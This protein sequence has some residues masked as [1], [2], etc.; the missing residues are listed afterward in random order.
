MS[1][2]SH[3]VEQLLYDKATDF[4]IAKAIKEDIKI[5][6]ETLPELFSQT[7]G[8][9][10]LLKHTRKI[11]DIIKLVYKITLRNMFGDYVPMRHSIPIALAALGSYGREQLCMHSDIDLMI[12]YEDIPG[13]QTKELI[14]KMLYMFWDIGMKLGHRVH[15]VSELS[16]VAKSDITIKSAIL[17]SRFIE[18][19]KLIWTGVE[20]R[21][22]EIRKD[23]PE[24]FIRAKLQEQKEL[25]QK[26]PLSMEPNLKEGVGGFRNANLVYWIAKLLYDVPRIKELPSSIINESEYKQ[27]RIALEF[28]FRVRS[29]LHLTTGKKE[30]RLRLERIPEVANL[31]GYPNT[32]IA[33]MRFAKKTIEYLRIINLLTKVWLEELVTKHVPDVYSGYLFID[34]EEHSL[35]DLIVFLNNNAKEQFKPHPR[36]LKA[37]I[38]AKRPE[39]LTKKLYLSISDIFYQDASY[40]ILKTIHEARLL[41]YVMPPIKKVIDLPQFDGYHQFSVDIHSMYCVSYLENIEDPFLAKLYSGLDKKEKYIL[42]IATFLHDC[43]KGRKK[44]HALVGVSLFRIFASKIGMDAERVDIGI[45]L[46]QHHDL[47]SITAQREDLYSEKTILQF[48]SRFNTKKLLDMIYLLTYADMSAV[49]KGV[50]TNFTSRL[51]KTLYQESIEALKHDNILSSTA[52]KLKKL[53]TLK[54]SNAYANLPKKIQKK[55]LSIPSNELFIHN[56]IHQILYIVKMTFGM[57]DFTYTIGNKRFLTIEIVRQKSFNLGYLLSKLS[58]LNVVNLQIAK[59]FDD[60]KYF[61]IDFNDVIDE[62]EIPIIEDIVKEAFEGNLKSKPAKPIIYKDEIEIDCEHSREYGI[63]R[64]RTKDQ[65]GLLAYITQLFETLKVDIASTKIHTSKYKVNDLFLIQKNGNFCNNTELI[66]KKLTE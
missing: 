63:M 11:D 42:K 32:P 60:I 28:L 36:L 57:I 19:S 23:E 50:Y 53:D 38:H 59:L 61:R 65:K 45:K 30:D 47:M 8:K 40:S 48:A 15:A 13:Y 44:D 51:L 9:D 6:F 5:Y 3:K 7:G 20:N 29:A 54:K 49:G 25:H 55:I 46:I 26:F 62:S 56:D 24:K 66:I 12:A 17:E 4:E 34:A 58:R 33:H 41:K 52:R 10:F 35:F 1:S 37:L 64:L 18:G 27:Y 43:G 14:E 2:L 39:R 21:I 16:E 22:T 31:L